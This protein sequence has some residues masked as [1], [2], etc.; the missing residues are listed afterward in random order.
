M[1]RTVLIVTVAKVETEAVLNEFAVLG[2]PQAIEK[3]GVFFTD[4]GVLNDFSV[5][6]AISGMGSGSSS[7][8]QATVS[9]AIRLLKPLAVRQ[10]KAAI[11]RR[12]NF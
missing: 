10:V 7:G 11:R 12:V 4:L 2:K 5:Y 9:E 3:G 8:S 6:L 1:S